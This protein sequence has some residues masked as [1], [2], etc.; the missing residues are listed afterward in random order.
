MRTALLRLASGMPF[1]NRFFESTP[2]CC[3]TCAAAGSTSAALGWLSWLRRDRAARSSEE[4]TAD[5]SV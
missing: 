5:S 4:H 1:V 3:P 2:M